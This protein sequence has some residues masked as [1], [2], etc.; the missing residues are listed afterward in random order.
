MVGA[1]VLFTLLLRAPWAGAALGLDEGGLSTI[2][3]SWLRDHGS[4]YGSYWIDRPPLLLLIWKTALLAGP[5]GIRLLGA[6]AAAALVSLG[7]VIG[8][9][10]GGRRVGVIA[11]II[12]A[13]L[14]SSSALMAVFT[15]AEL[16]AAVPAAGALALLMRL[17]RRDPAGEQRLP[18]ELLAAGA[19]ACAA[20]LIKQ[21]SIDA[22][23][24][25]LAF[26]AVMPAV[27]WRVRASR[28][29]LGL[30]GCALALAPALAWIALSDVT[31][32]DM[33]YALIGFRVDG[34]HA[35]QGTHSS[36]GGRLPRLRLPLLA[37]G[38]VF[39]LPLSAVGLLRAP[40]MLRYVLLAWLVSAIFA[41]LAG[42][43][44][45]PHYL[46]Q[47]IV[48][49]AVLAALSLAA[50]SRQAIAQASVGAL[51][52]LAVAI[53]SLSAV[54]QHRHPY[55]HDAQAVGRYVHESARPGDTIYVQY[56]RANVGYYSGLASPFPY[57]WSLMLRAI[58]SADEHLADLLASDRRP[59]WIV[60]WQS[61]GAFGQSETQE[62]D[63]AIANGYR[64][65]AAPC[66]HQLLLRS[67]LERT[68]SASL[69]TCPDKN[70]LSL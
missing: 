36:L 23:V 43:S 1:C 2:A 15:P 22:A 70:S 48:P 11:A 69:P 34:L 66:G 26:V 19:L 64:V 47:L 32:G 12:V 45:W 4:L 3:T 9:L 29:A 61:P 14:A 57:Q 13:C 56:A 18:W 28:T 31:L 46:I 51:A 27:A 37:S 20:G 38:M 35:L 42:G 49:V 65:V 67:G 6:L 63:A 16:L 55:Q 40:R 52:V 54:H 50:L 59:T 68:L 58:P 41:V 17:A 39:V 7:A 30:A 62:I 44:Y 10:I 60:Q 24:A 25:C 21:S 53:A 5:E 33:Y 8:S